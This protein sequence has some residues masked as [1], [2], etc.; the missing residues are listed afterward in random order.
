LRHSVTI[1]IQSKVVS[2]RNGFGL[3]GIFTDVLDRGVGT[4]N[5]L[6]FDVSPQLQQGRFGVVIEPG[7]VASGEKCIPE[8]DSASST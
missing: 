4:E 6:Q 1:V 2:A 7:V 5:G 3:A 8:S